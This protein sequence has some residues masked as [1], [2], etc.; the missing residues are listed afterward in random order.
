M[1][2]AGRLAR[3]AD[4]PA[5]GV[6]KTGAGSVLTGAAALAALLAPGTAVPVTGADGWCVAATAGAVALEAGLA[7]ELAGTGTCEVREAAGVTGTVAVAPPVSEVTGVAAG[8]GGGAVT[9]GAA[10]RSV[11][12]VD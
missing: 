11:G 1:S 8:L 4:G 7:V 6:G 10:W 5:D 9:V 2:A 12:A 3:V